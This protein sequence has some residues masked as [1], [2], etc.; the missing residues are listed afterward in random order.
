MCFGVTFRG[1]HNAQADIEAILKHLRDIYKSEIKKI[2]RVL[3]TLQE[4]FHEGAAA[5]S[6]SQFVQNVK[7]LV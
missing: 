5:P 6:F 2:D 3:N 7:D 1:P 4:R